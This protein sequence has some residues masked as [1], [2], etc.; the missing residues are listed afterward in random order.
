M[1]N[2]ILLVVVLFI[3][4][5]T[6]R[7]QL[8]EYVG[9]ALTSANVLPPGQGGSAKGLQAPPGAITPTTPVNPND[10]FFNP[11]GSSGATQNTFSVPNQ[12]NYGGTVI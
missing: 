7:G 6:A 12:N 1:K 11:N 8:V 5:I 4:Y 3:V 2:P 10:Y 9:L